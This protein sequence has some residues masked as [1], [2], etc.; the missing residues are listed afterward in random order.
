[1][2]AHIEPAGFREWHPGET[3][4]MDTVH[5]AEYNSSGPGAHAAERDP[6]IQRLTPAQAEGYRAKRIL[7][8]KDRWDPT[9]VK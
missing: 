4:Y 5:Y 2:G 7:R 3:S 1:M 8:G 6:H 9:A